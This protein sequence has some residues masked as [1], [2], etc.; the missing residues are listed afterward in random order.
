MGYTGILTPLIFCRVCH[1]PL[2][3]FLW[4]RW[5]PIPVWAYSNSRYLAVLPDSVPDTPGPLSRACM[6]PIL[7]MV[8]RAPSV[9]NNLLSGLYAEVCG[10]RRILMYTNQTSLNNIIIT[11]YWHL[12]SDMLDLYLWDLWHN[13]LSCSPLTY[14]IYATVLNHLTCLF[15]GFQPLLFSVIVEATRVV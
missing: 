13:T 11:C 1:K 8:H 15:L 12:T 6:R 7:N 10:M 3:L 9:S 2:G 5:H 14:D 4:E